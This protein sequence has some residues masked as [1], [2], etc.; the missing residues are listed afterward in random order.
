MSAISGVR[1]LLA[2]SRLAVAASLLAMPALSAAQAWPICSLVTTRSRC[3]SSSSSSDHSRG[4]SSSGTPRTNSMMPTL[5]ARTIGM[6]ERRPKASMMPSGNAPTMPVLATTSVT[7]R[8]PQRDVGTCARPNI[9]PDS[10]I[11]ASTG[12]STSV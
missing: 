5:T 2:L 1:G 7:M 6:S 12:N 10:K 9:P 4:L 11:T 8:P 3:D